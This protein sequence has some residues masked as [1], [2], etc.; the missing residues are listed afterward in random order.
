M[1]LSALVGAG[2]PETIDFFLTEEEPQRALE[3]CRRDE[4][5][6]RGLLLVAP[7]ELDASLGLN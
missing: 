6:W 5:E 7:V 2:D 1:R 4:P 3:G